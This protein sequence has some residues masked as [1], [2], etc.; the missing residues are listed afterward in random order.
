MDATSIHN[1]ISALSKP[2][3]GA[4]FHLGEAKVYKIWSS[5]VD[6]ESAPVNFEPGKVLNNDSGRLLVKCGGN[7]ALWLN[8][9]EPKLQ[10]Q[11]NAYL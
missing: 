3:P 1:L 2:Y 7:T 6:P 8:E 9:V 5:T 11:S 4:E 10:L